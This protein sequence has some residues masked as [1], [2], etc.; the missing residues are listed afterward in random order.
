[1]FIPKHL[2]DWKPEHMRGVPKRRCHWCASGPHRLNELMIVLEAPMRF[3]FCKDRCWNAWQQRR[4]DGEIVSWLRVPSG[5]RAKILKRQR[6]EA[7]VAKDGGKRAVGLC[8]RAD[9]Q[10]PVQTT[11][12]LPHEGALSNSGRGSIDHLQ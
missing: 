12:E 10:V 11:D 3:H 8:N 9:V 1:M 7:D 4:H 5:I 2:R 6:D